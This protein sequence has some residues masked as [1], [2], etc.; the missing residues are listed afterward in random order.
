MV[1]ALLGTKTLSY[2]S[3][4]IAK[5][6]TTYLSKS[7][8]YNPQINKRMISVL[9]KEITFQCMD[10][11]KIAAQSWQTTS[12]NIRPTTNEVNIV[13]QHR[14]E[15][16]D[17]EEHILCL[18]GWMDNCR[19]FHKL[20]PAIINHYNNKNN[21]YDQNTNNN[22]NKTTTTKTCHLIAMDFLGHGL[23]SHKGIDTPPS[24]LVDNVFY[25]NEVIHQLQWDGTNNN[26]VAGNNNNDHI[27]P[28]TTTTTSTT[29]IVPFTLIG[30][31]M[32]AG[33]ACLYAAAFPEH[34]KKLIL[35]EGGMLSFHTLHMCLKKTV[36]CV[37]CCK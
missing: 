36:G 6:I 8:L 32:G 9:P 25:V 15:Q 35:L 5:N 33:I 17:E 3:S 34:V 4:G 2:L 16:E 24:L 13:Q 23:S 27:S 29:K 26:S 21:N 28:P 14:E 1:A 7:L 11:M 37:L 12:T 31:S 10:G 19:S 18:H 22:D 20:A 30:H